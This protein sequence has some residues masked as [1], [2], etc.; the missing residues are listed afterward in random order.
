MSATRAGRRPLLF[1][2]GFGVVSLLIAGLIS[3]LASGD[4]DGLD[5]VALDGC[6]VVENARGEE[7]L[8][9]TCIAQ[10]EGEHALG[11]SPLADYA[12]GD[13]DGTGGVAGVI[14]VAVTLAVAGGV[15]L[16]L[17]RRRE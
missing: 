3:Y 2:V 4:P 5:T 16:L 13:T 14:G 8:Q 12:L 7:D 10:N 6:T 17:G 9:G 15:F 11:A 1:F